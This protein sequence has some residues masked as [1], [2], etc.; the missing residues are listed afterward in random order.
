MECKLCNKS[1]GQLEASHIISE[2]FYDKVYDDIHRYIPIKENNYQ[3]IK[4]E[5]LG[6]R[7]NLLCKE[8]ENK[9]SKWENILK[10][11]FID[12]HNE[13][14]KFLTFDVIKDRGIL[15][16]GLKYNEFKKAILSILWRMSISSLEHFKSYD[17]GPYEEDLRIILLNDLPVD[18]NDYSI[19]I[20]KLLYEKREN[21]GFIATFPMS[22][23]ENAVIQRFIIYGLDIWVV[24]SKTKKPI[25]HFDILYLKNSGS[26]IIPYLEIN[27]KWIRGDIWKRIYDD[28]VKDFFE[29]K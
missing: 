20:S 27:K 6:Y 3:G 11:D 23:I 18:E 29:K 10:K 14:S 12:I 2:C 28:D 21:A 7:E 25:K 16:S 1:V 24:T 4:I 19:I 8:C 22:R 9:F 15:V 17:L 5:Q 13:E 26:I